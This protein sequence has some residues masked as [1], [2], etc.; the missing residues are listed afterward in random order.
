MAFNALREETHG[1]VDIRYFGWVPGS[2]ADFNRDFPT[3][4]SLGAGIIILG[5][6]LHRQPRQRG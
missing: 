2:I 5:S 6:R 1:K 4:K 3:A